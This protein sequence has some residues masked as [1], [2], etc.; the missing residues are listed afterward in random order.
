[1]LQGGGA[2]NVE[3][4]VPKISIVL[5]TFNRARFIPQA[6]ASI[7]QQ[8]FRD[9]ELIVVDDG[10]TD[11]SEE[12]IARF[13]RD[14]PNPIRYLKQENQGP[15]AARNLGIRNA[16]GEYIAFFDSDDT[17]EAEHLEVCVRELDANADVDWVYSSF[18]RV[19]IESG[20]VIDADAFFETGSRAEFLSLKTSV[21]GD[22][23]VIDDADALMCSIKSGLCVGL[24][25]SVV[26]RKVFQKVEFPPFRVGEDQVLYPRALAN[27]VK[28]GYVLPVQATAYVH[29]G[30][31]SEVAG[32]LSTD[33]YVETLSEL[34]RAFE[35]I[36]DLPLARRERQALEHRIANESFW[37]LGYAC[38][39]AGRNEDALEYLQKGLRLWPQNLMFWKTY[40]V[41]VLRVAVRNVRLRVSRLGH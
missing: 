11:G 3:E 33:K 21:R 32:V 37:N 23:H 24:R 4:H 28:F 13:S 34:I 5:P 8:T 31:I 27:G 2:M 20:E 19:R 10:S 7:T 6:I 39:S 17:W 25:T 15:A 16:R 9:W 35:S 1:M 22:L 36:C 18:R 38:L 41:A 26:R 40:V 12:I 14:V 30:N 29:D